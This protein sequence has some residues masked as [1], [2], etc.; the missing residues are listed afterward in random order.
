MPQTLVNQAITPQYISHE[1][2]DI[3]S[4]HILAHLSSIDSSLPLENLTTQLTR[5]LH[6]ATIGSFHIQNTPSKVE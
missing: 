3:S 6:F 2:S 4:Q 1:L 5:V